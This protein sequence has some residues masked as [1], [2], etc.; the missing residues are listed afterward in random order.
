MNPNMTAGWNMVHVFI[1]FVKIKKNRISKH[2]F[3]LLELI[4]KQNV[5]INVF[6]QKI[7]KK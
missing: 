7:E 6:F 5:R 2:F 1:K 4:E 3:L